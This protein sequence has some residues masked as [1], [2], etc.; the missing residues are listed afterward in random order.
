M[1]VSLMSICMACLTGVENTKKISDK[2]VS[3]LAPEI[4]DE[5][6][7]Y[8]TDVKGISFDQMKKGE[9]FYVTDD[10]I[11]LI[12]LPNENYNPDSLKLGS[13]ILTYSNYYE[14]NVLGNKNTVYL[15]FEDNAGVK[16]TYPT[17]KTK[18]ELISSSKSGGMSIPFMVNIGMVEKAKNLLKG[19]ELYIRTSLWYNAKEE[20]IDGRKFI[21]VQI[22]D[23]LPGNK[24]LPLKVEFTTPEG[25]VAYLFLATEDAPMLN[26]M[27]DNA[28]SLTDIRKK[29]PMI[30]DSNWNL[31]V[32]G[33]IAENMTK[34]EC[35][36][37]LGAPNNIDQFPSYEGLREMWMYDNGVY[38]MF[39][40]GILKK[41]RK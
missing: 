37:S 28:F 30:T 22:T 24:I 3:K 21:N 40:D 2:D 10:Q 12:F 36:L 38:L 39:E 1:C 16:Y 13:H 8:L 41:Y 34:D 32:A 14:D 5:K 35:R 23:V 29:Y 6:S 33:K 4:K 18:D 26:R 27:F 31:I 17:G 15:V 25:I 11:R 20:M 7:G 9:K 19:K